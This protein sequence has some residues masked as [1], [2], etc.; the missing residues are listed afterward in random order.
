MSHFNRFDDGVLRP[1]A[2]RQNEA[3]PPHKAYYSKDKDGASA[4]FIEFNV[5]NF[6]TDEMTIKVEGGSSFI[7]SSFF[8][9]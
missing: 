9:K 1:F 8:F 6:K 3:L 5:G 7:F 2:S 4:Y